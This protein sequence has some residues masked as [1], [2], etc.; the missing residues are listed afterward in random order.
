MDSP[1]IG[2][3]MQGFD[4]KIDLIANQMDHD[5]FTK[6]ATGEED[7]QFYD[8]EVLQTVFITFRTTNMRN[9]SKEPLMMRRSTSFT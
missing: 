2:K 7:Q 1:H 9:S 5:T 4:Y 8:I 3:K 6:A